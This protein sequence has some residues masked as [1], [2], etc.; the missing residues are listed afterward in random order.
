MNAFVPVLCPD[1]VLTSHVG[2]PTSCLLGADLVPTSVKH[3]KKNVPQ[4]EV[5]I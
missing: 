5:L 2:V 4:N 1:A 3:C